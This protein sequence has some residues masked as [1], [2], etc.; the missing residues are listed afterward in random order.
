MPHREMHDYAEEMAP[1]RRAD[2]AESE[3]ENK[4]GSEDEAGPSQ[5][6]T[7]RSN[8]RRK[9]S[10]KHL[11]SVRHSPSSCR[12]SPMIGRDQSFRLQSILDLV[13]T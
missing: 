4:E 8:S 13:D 9:P 5:L 3:E 11:R 2:G 6:R 12:S 7:R 1:S 10:R